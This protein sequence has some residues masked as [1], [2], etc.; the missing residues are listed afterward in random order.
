MSDHSNLPELQIEKAQLDENSQ[1]SR[2]RLHEQAVKDLSSPPPHGKEQIIKNLGHGTYQHG[3]RQF[4]T[5]VEEN[6]FHLETEK[7]S[8]SG[9]GIKSGHEAHKSS[10]KH[11]HKNQTKNKNLD[12][13]S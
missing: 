3:N 1:T 8:S 11:N 12:Y 7:H 2:A 13:A 9:E 4:S 5:G 6:D 10:Y